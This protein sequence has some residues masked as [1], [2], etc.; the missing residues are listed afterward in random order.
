[1]IRV[2]SGHVFCHI[3]LIKFNNGTNKSR[4]PRRS[5]QNCLR[6]NLATPSLNH[7]KFLIVAGINQG[8]RLTSHFTSKKGK[9]LACWPKM[10]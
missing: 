3:N 6:S 4:R 7:L 2:M 5:K 1:M 9:T 8:F 10:S